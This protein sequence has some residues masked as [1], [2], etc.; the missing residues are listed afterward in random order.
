MVTNVMARGDWRPK[1]VEDLEPSAW[2]AL[3]HEGS[4]L[5]IA[6]PGAGKTEF[7]AQRAAFLLETGRCPY[8]FR[9]LAIS[10]KRDADENLRHRVQSRCSE[11]HANR[12][13]SMTFDAFTKGTV[14]R[15]RDALPAVWRP[16][17]PYEV[18]FPTRTQVDA[19][20][21]GAVSAA[22]QQWR[23]QIA[24]FVASGF[25]PH[26]VGAHR[27]PTRAIEP[28]T[29]Q[30]FAVKLWWEERMTS[31]QSQL[32][33]TCLNR[34]AELLIRANPQLRRAIRV[35]YPYVFVDEFQ[36]TTHAQ[37]DFLSSTFAGS[38]SQITA[39]GDDK[40]RIMAWAGARVDAFA[41][42][43]RDFASVRIPLKQNHRSSPALVGLQRVI[44]RAISDT[45]PEVESKAPSEI[46]DHVAET[47]NFESSKEEA[48]HVAHWLRYDMNLRE[49]HPRDY[50][51]L[52]RQKADEFLDR[53]GEA[54][55]KIGLQIRNESRS[56]GRTTLQD[57]LAEEVTRIAL[58][59][60][61]LGAQER[62]PE[63][64]ILA[65]RALYRLRG[66]EAEDDHRLREVEEELTEYTRSIK[67]LLTGN[68]QAA[69]AAKLA[70]DTFEFLSTDDIRSTFPKYATGDTLD[71]ATEAFHL[72]LKACASETDSWV[73]CLDRY[74]G[75]D[76]TPLMTVHK[77]KGLEY[78]TVL[79]LGLDDNSWWSY[80][81]GE[82]EGLSTF[83]VALS[84]AKQRVIFTYCRERRRTRIADLYQLLT[85][86]GVPERVFGS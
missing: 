71:I 58:A 81:S 11:D 65:S 82:V 86:A 6:G 63:E 28:R 15:F 79:F 77:S 84:R 74:E 13:D 52:V 64:W 7:L 54:F 4:T 31:D 22:P 43:E 39:V 50:V 33:F 19:F 26:I 85:E 32:T 76:S 83:F 46:S 72:Y 67:R 34:L 25:E 20:L 40:Q 35:T 49:T 44:A 18:S 66:V 62:A 27:L 29:G 24:S 36:D 75:R 51:L 23:S 59:V 30:D 41:A 68:P 80:K 17:S 21:Q 37:Y 9:I 3:E 8:P 70:D 60:L 48:L 2:Q 57:L 14:D 73:E 16:S 55:E 38:P 47:W 56:L 42:F 10:F 61:R 53:L 69:E 12:F 45:A 5:V 78:D 1:G